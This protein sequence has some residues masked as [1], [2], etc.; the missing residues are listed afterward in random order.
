MPL[1]SVFDEIDRLFDELVR[2]PWGIVSRRLVPAEIREVE[3]GWIVELPAEG[4]RA[5]DLK[6]D[7]H[8]SQLTVSGHRHEQRERRHGK[9]ARTQTQRDVSLH[10]T[11]RLPSG[12]DPDDVEAKLEGSTL[13]IHIG[14]RKP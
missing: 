2:R 14:R 4:V 13:T 6:V 7:V 12:A 9:T 1:P 5:A 10:R 11:V 8:G 3:D